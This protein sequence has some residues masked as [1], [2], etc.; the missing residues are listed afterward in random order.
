MDL[1]QIRGLLKL[2][3]HQSRPVVGRL[4]VDGWL[5][6]PSRSSL[7]VLSS[8]SSYTHTHCKSPKSQGGQVGLLSLLKIPKYDN[9][10][11]NFYNYSVLRQ[12]EFVPVLKMAPKGTFDDEIQGQPDAERS[13]KLFFAKMTP[14][15]STPTKGSKLAAGYDLKR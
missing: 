11:R 4:C 14:N 9:L 10:R 12:K 8:L 2:F 5:N 7:S 6:V 13:S 1:N 3:S 15:A